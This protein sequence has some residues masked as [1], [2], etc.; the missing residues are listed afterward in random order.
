MVDFFHI[1]IPLGSIQSIRIFVL[2]RKSSQVVVTRV[3]ASPG[4]K[5]RLGKDT[6]KNL[7]R[8]NN[9][10]HY[11]SHIDAKKSYLKKPLI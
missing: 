10:R 2:F 8:E 1:S 9:Q 5:L 7:K 11:I 3:L 6:I 4:G